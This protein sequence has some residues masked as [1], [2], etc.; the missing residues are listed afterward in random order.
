MD[1]EIYVGLHFGLY[2][3]IYIWIYI[4]IGYKPYALSYRGNDK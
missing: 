4:F 1:I 2:R 3:R